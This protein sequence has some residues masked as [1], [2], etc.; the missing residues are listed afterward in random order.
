MKYK[1]MSGI[2]IVALLVLPLVLGLFKPDTAKDTN[3]YMQHRQ[4]PGEQTASLSIDPGTFRTHLPIVSIDTDGAPVPGSWLQDENG[5]RTGVQTTDG[6]EEIP[7]R[8]RWI[9]NDTA[10]KTLQDE[11][12][13]TNATIRIRGNSSRSFDKKAIKS[14][15][16]MG[17]DRTRTCPC[18]AWVP[19]TTGRCTD[20]FWTRRSSATTC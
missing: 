15:S 9:D 13:D 2:A 8:I 11:G 16:S 14:N 3:R 20:R 5:T 4:A 17:K 18:L 7:A 19:M 12:V 1:I 6:Q 10:V